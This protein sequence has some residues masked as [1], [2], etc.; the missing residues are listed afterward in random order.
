[1]MSNIDGA[2]WEGKFQFVK[3][4]IQWIINQIDTSVIKG[5]SEE[6]LPLDHS[7]KKL[8]QALLKYIEGIEGAKTGE[9]SIL[10][11]VAMLDRKTEHTLKWHINLEKRVTHLEEVLRSIGKVINE[12]GKG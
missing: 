7:R 2:T 3:E 6:E 12:Q 11:M 5:R 9:E 1:M 10:D 8:L 4:H